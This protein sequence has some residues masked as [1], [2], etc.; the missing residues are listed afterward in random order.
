MNDIIVSTDIKR[1]FVAPATM[2]LAGA[3]VEL[4][5]LEEREY[6]FSTLETKQEQKESKKNFFRKNVEKLGRLNKKSAM[7]ALAAFLT[8]SPVVNTS[9]GSA[10]KE[11]GI[12]ECNLEDGSI[13]R[14][15]NYQEKKK[16]VAFPESMI[17]RK[18]GKL[19]QDYL[20][21]E[22]N[23]IP[24]HAEVD[25]FSNM[26]NLWQTKVNRKNVTK[27]TKDNAGKV[28]YSVQKLIVGKKLRKNENTL[29]DN[30]MKFIP[31]IFRPAFGELPISKFDTEAPKGELLE[32][33]ELF[34]E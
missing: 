31:N 22:S 6:S 8:L 2:D 34:E 15:Q 14:F 3:T 33:K 18:A 28:L 16:V 11:S 25:Y 1:L 21:I 5:N 4:V 26:L 30:A 24:T 10:E 32:V 12:I 19:F 13:N 23:V 27:A 17:D 20:G 29:G 7:Y 9:C